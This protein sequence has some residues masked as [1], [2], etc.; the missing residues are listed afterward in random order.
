MNNKLSFA[1][2]QKIQQLFFSLT[3]KS[4]IDKSGDVCLS[5]DRH[6]MSV[7]THHAPQQHGG[8][9]DE[10]TDGEELRCVVVHPVLSG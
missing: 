10:D 5:R 9:A 4:I 7:V 3:A 2:I 6:L 8:Q 1:V